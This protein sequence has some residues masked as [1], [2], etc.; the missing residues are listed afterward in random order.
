MQDATGRAQRDAT[1][2]KEALQEAQREL[3]DRVGG[4]EQGDAERENDENED[5]DQNGVNKAPA[6]KLG[7]G[8]GL[9]IRFNTAGQPKQQ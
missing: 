7:R 1:E 3:E 6:K 2:A 5:A 4:K 9:G 8:R